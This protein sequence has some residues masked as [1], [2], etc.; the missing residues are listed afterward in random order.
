MLKIEQDMMI[1]FAK[2]PFGSNRVKGTIFSY[3]LI[4]LKWKFDL[5]FR[6]EDGHRESLYGNWNLKILNR[7]HTLENQIRLAWFLW[8]IDGESDEVI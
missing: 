7:S 1:Q 8:V 6:E 4:G 5:K 2:N 3:K